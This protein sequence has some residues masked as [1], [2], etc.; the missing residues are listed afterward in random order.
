MRADNVVFGGTAF[1]NG[2]YIPFENEIIDFTL[3]RPTIYKELLKQKYNDGIRTKVIEHILDDSYY[4]MY[5]KDKLLPI[6]PIRYN[7]RLF[8]YDKDILVTG[9]QDIFNKIVERR[10]AAIV[11]IHPVIC[12][13]V[14]DFF[15]IRAFP[16]FSRQAAIILDIDIPAD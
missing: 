8:L 10:P 16:K 3:A 11:P 12:H 5:A 1:T 14:T 6:P 7:K 13:T 15:T 9:W 4:R 2:V